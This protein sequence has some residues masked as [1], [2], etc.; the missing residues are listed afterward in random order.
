MSDDVANTHTADPAARRL[1]CILSA[2]SLPYA[3]KGL[4]SLFAHVLEPVSL[5]LITDDESDKQSIIQ[6]VSALT[7]PDRHQW[8][9]YSKQE[10][11]ERADSLF[12]RYPHLYRFRSGHPCWRKISDPLLYAAPGEEAVLLDP[13]LFFPNYFKFEST[14]ASGLRLMWQ[15]PSCLL[16]ESVVRTAYRQGIALAH[17]VDIGVAQLRN[18]LDLEWLDWLIGA[19]GGKDIPRVMHVEAIVWAA[20]AMR[21]GGS[22]YDPVHWHCW[23]NSQWKRIA[24]KLGVPG[25]R[26]LAFEDFT[27][28]KCFHAGGMAKWF[29]KEACERG[30][31][32]PPRSITASTPGHAYQELTQSRYDSDQ[33]VKHIARSLGYYKIFRAGA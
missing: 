8:V 19:L 3:E 25:T 17:H 23:Q 9:V 24:L 18:D 5:S 1:Y 10:V 20:L 16:P 13:D 12:M 2:R 7:I 29:V 15:P 33:R 32:P 27:S 6:A 26:I 4:A 14:P 31:F 11:D 22:Y 30:L 28:T 21:I